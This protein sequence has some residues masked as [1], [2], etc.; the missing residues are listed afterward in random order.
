M[1][2]SICIHNLYKIIHNID[3]FTDFW[4]QSSVVSVS[5]LISVLNEDNVLTV[6]WGPGDRIGAC[7][8]YSMY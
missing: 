3:Q 8:I 2:S 4:L 6:F 7:F 1:N 5:F